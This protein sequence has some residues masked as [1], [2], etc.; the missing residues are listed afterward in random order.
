M[1]M[2]GIY[3]A[4]LLYEEA[5]ET[6]VTKRG[7]VIVFPG[8]GYEHLSPRESEPI[9]RALNDG[10]YRGVI[11]HYDVKSPVLGLRPL[12]QA[13][14]AV[15]SVKQKF[16]GEPVYLMGFSA[17]AHC[18]ASL[19]VHFDDTDWNGMPLFS[20]VESFLK[21]QNP[22]YRTTE[23]GTELFRPDGMILAYPVISGG[24][25][26]HRGS[27]LRLLGSREQYRETYG[28]VTDYDRALRWFSLEQQ[29]HHSTCP[30]FIWQ[31]EPDNAVPVQNS[32]L[33]L[34]ACI[35][36]G[37]EVEY[38]MFP[39]GVHGMSLA[40][41][42]V[43]DLGKNRITDPHIASWFPMALRWLDEIMSKE[44]I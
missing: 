13:A 43:E 39:H 7:T 22:E 23:C 12:K 37:I 31:T 6:N 5:Q 27:F 29:V 9:V 33:F 40:T 30:S 3:D 41:K 18:A 38:H 2:H 20:E 8:G 4:E 34:E 35:Q 32:L 14:W 26:A 21:D 28:D 25:W 1:V 11:F 16:P 17:G 24:E 15:A 10:G 44:K 36:K 19:G 42:E